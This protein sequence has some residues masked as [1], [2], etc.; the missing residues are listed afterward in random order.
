MSGDYKERNAT[1]SVWADI[2]AIKS[3]SVIEKE[4]VK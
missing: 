4:H 1:G 3:E 2:C